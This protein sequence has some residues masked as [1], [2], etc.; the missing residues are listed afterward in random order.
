MKF[1]VT[2]AAFLIAAVPVVCGNGQDIVLVYTEKNGE[3]GTAKGAFLSREDYSEM[4]SNKKEVGFRKVLELAAKHFEAKKEID[5][6]G[7]VRAVDRWKFREAIIRAI[8]PHWTRGKREIISFDAKH[9][10]FFYL[11]DFFALDKRGDSIA[12]ESVVVLTTGK[13]IEIENHMMTE[14][15]KSTAEQSCRM[16][17][18]W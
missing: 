5:V 8:N 10:E 14:V 11:V 16:L 9:P 13:V 3:A 2:I 18:R 12:T 6:L 17:D 4:R 15:E 1:Y 7:M